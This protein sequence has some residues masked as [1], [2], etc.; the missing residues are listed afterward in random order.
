MITAAIKERPI[1]F[2]GPMARA[3][4][5]GTK[6]MTRRIMKPQPQESFTTDYH[7]DG[8]VKARRS[9]GFSW[10]PKNDGCWLGVD[11]ERMSRVCPHGTI[12]ERLWVKETFSDPCPLDVACKNFT[13][14][15]RATDPGRKVAADFPQYCELEGLTLVSKELV[16]YRQG[17]T[18]YSIEVFM[19]SS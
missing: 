3:I 10:Q 12:G 5:A 14:F 16:P 6:S 7:A 18:D 15:Y 1:I 2:S 9:C 11:D 8:S 4:L 17:D 19:L 13:G